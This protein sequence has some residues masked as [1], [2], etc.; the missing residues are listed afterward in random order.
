M[1]KVINVDFCKKKKVYSPVVMIT[2]CSF[3]EHEYTYLQGINYNCD[4][5][6][7]NTADLKNYNN[8]QDAWYWSETNTEWYD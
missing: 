3:P 5:S 6:L 4:Y 1:G 8:L 2:N 7:S